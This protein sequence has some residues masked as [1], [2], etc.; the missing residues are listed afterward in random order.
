MGNE[1]N[2]GGLTIVALGTSLPELVTSLSAAWKW[3][4]DIAVGNAVGSNI[5]NLLWILGVSSLLHPIPFNVA[6]KRRHSRSN[7]VNQHDFSRN[8][9]RGRF[10]IKRLE[11]LFFLIVY[12]LYLYY[13]IQRG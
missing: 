3:N 12:G 10:T 11:G 4:T 7:R 8:G 6:S 2:L 13:V 5:F 1:R 9:G